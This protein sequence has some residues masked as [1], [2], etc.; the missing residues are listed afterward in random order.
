[1]KGKAF[2]FKLFKRVL[3]LIRPYRNLF[4][5][6]S[7]FVIV[8]AILAPFRPFLIQYTVDNYVLLGDLEGLFWMA[9]LM[10]VLLIFESLIRFFFTYNANWLGQSAIHNLRQRVFN[11]ISGRR[12][13]YF[14]KTPIGTLTTRTISDIE[15]IAQIFSQG[16][17]TLIGD[18]LQ[19]IAVLLMMF[20]TDWKLTLI[21]LATFPFLVICTYI[22]KE[23]VKASFQ[24]VRKYISKLNA[25]LQEQIT[26]MSIVQ[27]FNKEKEQ[28]EKFK[29]I[30]QELLNANLR[31]VMYYSIFFPMVEI[32]TAASLGLLVW[33]GAISVL[34]YEGSIG[35]I[36]AFILYI[37]MFFRPVRML[38]DKFNTLQ[39]G[40]VASER[41]FKVLDTDESIA[42]K[43]TIEPKSLK[44]NIEFKDVSFAYDD[45]NFVLKNISF[46][47]KTGKSVALVGST[48][49]GKSSIINVLSRFYEFQKGSVLVDGINIRDL[50]L[51][52]LHQHIGVILQDVF[53]FSGSIE[54]NISL[55]NPAITLKQI[56]EIARFTGINKFIEKLPGTY[57]YNVM[58]RGYALSAGQ[59]QLIAF[60]RAM[61]YNPKI[62]IL[63]EA[64]SSIDTETEEILQ[65][66]TEKLTQ[67]R[68]S[69]LIAHRL[70]TIQSANQILVIDKGEIIERGTHQELL[71]QKGKYNNLYEMQFQMVNL[72][73]ISY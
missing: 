13:K 50:K 63:D 71:N 34:N 46:E 57:Q 9:G 56:E 72:E 68:T 39:M 62:L 27:I 22:F 53:L 4:I 18:I 59:R 25:F 8:L 3:K 40:M 20:Y 7:I 69:I 6:T 28:A 48:G 45:E 60:L 35:V 43:G 19:L 66:A 44:G 42:D 49:A 11:H 24:D 1:M 29:S 5:F 2:D 17:L 52:N 36:I 67:N 10:F 65:E 14:D 32:I 58:E 12:L 51:S 64:T 55:R 26:G 30:N 70:S 47:V 61:V 38:A 23:K 15:T 54:E 73:E 33:W 16:L 41:V 37:N 31:A 21:S